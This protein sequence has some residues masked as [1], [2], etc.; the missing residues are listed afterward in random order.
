MQEKRRDS[1]GR[2]LR[3]GEVQRSDGKYMFRYVDADGERR[4][5]YSWKLVE[6]DSAP[7]GKKCDEA[8]RTIEQRVLRDVRDG[9]RTFSS[10]DITVNKLF[11]EFMDMREDLKMSTRCNYIVLYD[12]H[13]RDSLGRRAVGDVKHSDV[14]RLYLGMSKIDGLKISTIQSVNN[15]LWQILEMAVKDEIIRNNPATGAMKEISRVLK[16]E[17]EQRHALTIEQQSAWIDYVYG[18]NTYKR[19]GALFTVLLGTGMR[20]GEALGLRWQD[21]DFKKN[22]ISVNHSIAYKATEGGGYEYRVS[23]PKTK[24]GIRVIP[25]FKEVRDALQKEKHKKRG[26]TQESFSVDGYSG[27]IFVNT[28]GKVYTQSFIFDVIQNITADFNR[29]EML[30]AAKEN[31]EPA[32]MPKIS[33][34]IFRHTF[35]TRLCENESNLKIIQDV[36]GHKNIRTTMEIYNEATAE[37]KQL[38]FK[39]LEGKIRLA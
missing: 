38:S 39:N 14:Y 27:F 36:M 31:R 22:V 26:S 32:Y 16:E 7:S 12:K 17:Q 4:S 6:T 29:E 24:A 18:S 13:V 11:D 23:A 35:C 20:I 3:N 2:V 15:V 25:M 8:L 37:A 5:V 30:R 34:H 1:K 21:I 33:A 10:S 28:A 9:I 19:Y